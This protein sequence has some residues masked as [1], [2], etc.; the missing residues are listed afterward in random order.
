MLTTNRFILLLFM[1]LLL[2][3]CEE[4]K[5]ETVKVI[6]VE[7]NT[8]Q[9]FELEEIYHPSNFDQG[10]WVALAQGDGNTMY[11]CDQYGK[12]YQ[13]KI[14]AI[15]SAL[16]QKDVVPI[17]VEIGEAHGL[18]WAFNSLYVAVNKNWDDDIPDDQENGSGI[19]RITDTNNDGQLDAVKMLLKLEGSGEH[20]PHSFALS[21]D[22]KEVY[23]IAGN[24]TLIPDRVKENSR[25]PTNWGE[26]NLLK[27]FLDARGHANDVK[28]PGG[29]ITKFNPDGSSFELISVG[30]RNPFDMA[31]NS[32]GELFAYDAD[33]EWDIGMPWYRPT[34]IC[35]VTSGS[36]FGWRTGS[37][38]WPAYYPDNLPAVHN[39]EQG[40]PT[41]VLSTANLNL[42]IK[43]KNGLLAM[44][45]SFG[46]VYFIDLIPDGSSYKANREEFLSGT[47]LPLTDMVAGNDGHIYFAT[48]GRRLDS[49]LYRL[50]YTGTKNTDINST[51]SKENEARNLRKKLEEYHKIVSERGTELAWE[52]LANNDRFIRYAARLV[53]EH[54]PIE[55]WINRYKSE[56][57]SRKII[58]SS[59]ALNHQASSNLQDLILNKLLG[60]TFNNLDQSLK[61][62]LLRAYSLNFIRMGMPSAVTKKKIVQL[63][64]PTFPA[65]ESAISKET[66]QLLL[67]LDAD[68]ITKKI[69]EQLEYHT[70]QNTVTEGVEML[71][72]EATL[73]S[74]QYGPLIRDV[75]S[76][77]PPSEAIFYGMLLSNVENGWN[78][79]LRKRYFLWYFDVLGSKGGMSFKAY[80]EN[81]RQRA[82]THVPENRRDYFQE[83]SGIYSP[84]SAVA[85]LPQPIGPGKNYSGNDIQNAVWSGLDNYKGSIENG[86]RAF[87]A[88]T[89]ILCH[90]MRGEGG[91]AGPDLTQAHSKFSTY[92]LIFSI[93]SPNDEI[94]DQY[95]NTLFHL[96]ED[97]KIAG[98][99]KSEAGDS[100][101]IMP[102]PFNESYTVNIAKNAISKRELSPVS[103]MPPGLLNRLNEQ[104]IADLFAYIITGAD[105]NHKLY[106]GIEKE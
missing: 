43:Y 94:S 30:F 6:P 73:R 36:E 38:K 29:W 34:R 44:D 62:E 102:N 39:L 46:T 28:A 74:E 103:P 48:G 33:M 66:A 17:D 101:V 85:E 95:A 80:M 47:P 27:P 35:H 100:I 72:E 56:T 41:A 92:D 106:T 97:E 54:Q 37:G 10:S 20:G 70:E 96:G 16:S 63:L 82:L 87:A 69:V 78:E 88:A 99:I 67:F 11:S 68:G 31:F 55:S 9:N 71:S 8:P 12:L 77:M 90:R 86:K 89:C 32:D 49:H 75:I 25:I 98:R 22:G 53:L 14:P 51:N 64:N 79:D 52:H 24:H 21:P 26:D 2:F 105:E 18:L 45:W 104:E 61:M 1:L 93:Y 65:K 83:I 59:I 84:S 50:R 5:K 57:D 13:F 7:F 23:F 3:S 81:V 19:Y 15:G 76:K 40:S 4:E 91:A 60:I 42:P 58:E